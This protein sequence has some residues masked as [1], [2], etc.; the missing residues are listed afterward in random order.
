[1]RQKETSMKAKLKDRVIAESDDI[2]EEGGY[3]YFPNA[4]VRLD[5]LERG[6]EDG[7]RP[8]LP[9]RRPV[10]PRGRR[11]QTPRACRLA[12]RGAA[13]L[14]E[15]RCRPL[16]LLGRGRGGLS[17]QDY[18]SRRAAPLDPIK[19]ASIGPPTPVGI[20]TS[21]AVL[22]VASIKLIAT[23]VA[24]GTSTSLIDFFRKN[25]SYFALTNCL[26]IPFIASVNTGEFS[27]GRFA[28]PFIFAATPTRAVSLARR[29]WSWTLRAHRRTRCRTSSR[30]A[31]R[32]R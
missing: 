24:S 4:A 15:P 23:S 11:R 8:R 17:L 26:P 19:N 25:S 3:H 10:L 28:S 21:F 18:L 12:L 2:V 32:R 5:L 30:K 6:R 22:D 16:Q 7:L 20:G 9:A 31:A 1:M 13:P 29:A 27:T 14:D